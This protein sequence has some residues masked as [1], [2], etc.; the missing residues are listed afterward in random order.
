MPIPA[1]LAKPAFKYGAMA[2]AVVGLI[3][4]VVL[5]ID[6]V[7]RDG[8]KAGAA[9]V[10]GAVQTE[11]IKKLDEARKEKARTD[12]KNRNTPIDELIDRSLR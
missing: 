3:V 10:T 11:T 12:E 2:L 1:F 7:R 5:Y 4:V 6:G 9:E 8:K